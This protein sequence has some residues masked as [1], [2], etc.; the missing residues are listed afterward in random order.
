MKITSEETDIVPVCL[1]GGGGRVFGGSHVDF[2]QATAPSCY[3]DCF[4][5]IGTITQ[6][7]VSHQFFFFFLGGG[8]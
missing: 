3:T 4:C 8:D 5:E 2:V 7:F 1:P 6:E